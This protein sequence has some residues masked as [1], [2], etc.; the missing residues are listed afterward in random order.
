MSSGRRF[1]LAVLSLGVLSGVSFAFIEPTLFD[2]ERHLFVRSLFGGGI[3]S[4]FLCFLLDANSHHP[5]KIDFDNQLFDLTRP[6]NSLFIIGVTFLLSG[7]VCFVI[8]IMQS[9]DTTVSGYLMAFGTSLVS[10]SLLY[11]FYSNNLKN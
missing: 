10:G 1:N 3:F 11:I 9:K 4:F 2:S 5:K 6:Y 7:V 8:L